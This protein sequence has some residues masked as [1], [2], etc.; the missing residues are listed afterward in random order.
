MFLTGRPKEM[1]NK[2]GESLSPVEVDNVLLAHEKISKA[3]SFAVPDEVYGEDIGVAIVV[4]DGKSLTEP[5]L[6][7]WLKDK[8]TEVKVS[9]RIWFVDTIPKTATG[10]LQRLA[11]AKTM[12]ETGSK[13]DSRATSETGDVLEDL[14]QMWSEV[15]RIPAAEIKDTDKF[16][17]LSGDS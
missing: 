9:K 1:I 6:I 4:A 14:R 3:V 7:N 5:E 10:K 15:L 17:S 2:G 12:L 16:S 13:V 8:V 11:V